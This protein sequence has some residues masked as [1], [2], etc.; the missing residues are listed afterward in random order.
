MSKIG[1]QLISVPSGVSVEILDEE[2][3]VS[4]PK[5]TLSLRIPSGIS[6]VQKEEE[7]SLVSS[8]KSKTGKSLYG[9][10]RALLANNVKG[11]SDGWTKEL[12]LVGTGYRAEVVGGN[13]VLAVGY[14]HPVKISAPDSITFKV[15]K[16][17]ITIEGPNR[18]L[19]GQ[20][21]ANVRN[22]RP[23][24]PYKGKG[25]KYKDEVIRRKAG[26]AAKTVGAPA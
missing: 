2:V 18:E 21:A 15:E 12:E 3:K 14:S 9:T 20:I 6:V 1:K 7:I 10:T 22:V 4:G 23:P 11:V 13:L 16:T 5:G 17:F 8:K 25:I 24:E 26:K 19:V